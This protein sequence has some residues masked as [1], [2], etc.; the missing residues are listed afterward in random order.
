VSDVTSGEELAENVER[1]LVKKSRG[2]QANLEWRKDFEV[3]L[4][5]KEAG[6]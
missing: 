2:F 3:S 6:R 5:A 4:K 1:R